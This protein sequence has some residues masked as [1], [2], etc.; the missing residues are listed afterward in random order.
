MEVKYKPSIPGYIYGKPEVPKAPL[1]KK[2]FELL[3]DSLLWTK[4]DEENRK[5]L[6]EIISE[7]MKDL[8]S[9]IVSYFGSRDYLL[10][11][12]KDKQGQ[13]T[14]TEYVNNTV[15][16]LAQWLLDICYKPLD[17][18]FINYNYLIG[19]RHTYEEKGKADKIETIPHIPARY[20][21][22]C[23]F[24]ITAVLKNYIA[25]KV[26]DP[27]L[28]DKLYH[29]W[30]KLQVLTTAFFLIPYTKEGRW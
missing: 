29:T 2:D 16:R 10:Y 15:D 7:N 13:T 24:P 9:D 25:K 1:D 18:H 3:L 30:F 14:I 6:G 26:E 17:E 22:T 21:I 5:L 28:T 19:L 8:L 4:E 27:V 11:Y 12:F 20:M 23:L